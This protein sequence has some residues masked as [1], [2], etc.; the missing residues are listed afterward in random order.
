MKSNKNR[1]WLHFFIFPL[2]FSTLFFGLNHKAGAQNWEMFRGDPQHHAAATVSGEPL[3]RYPA[4]QYQTGGAIFS[5]PVVKD[6]RVYLASSDNFVY[7]LADSTGELIWRTKLGNWIESTPALAN[8]LLYVGCMDHRIYALDLADGRIRW[9]YQTQSWLES[10]PVVIGARL[11][12]GGT[13]HYLYC[14]NAL[15]GAEIWKYQVEK[16][17]YSSPAIWQ[18]FI[19]FGS[20][21]H[22]FYALDSL[23]N[24][25][26]RF[27]TGGYSIASS[28]A[29]VDSLV[30]FGTIDNGVEA[31][32]ATGVITSENNKII[33]LDALTGVVVWEHATENF[34]QMHTSPAVPGDKIYY[35]T[36]QGT[37]WALDVKDGAVNWQA[38]V[39]DSSLVWSSPATASEIIYVATYSGNLFLFS[40]DSGK[41]LAEFAIAVDSVFIH[42]SPAIADDHLFFGASDGK[43]YALNSVVPLAVRFQ[44][45]I[46]PKHAQLAQNYPNPFNPDTQIQYHLLLRKQVQ[47]KIFNSLGQ[48]IRTL[49]NG[50][51]MP[52]T[53]RLQW[54]GRNDQG[55]PVASGNYLYQIRAGKFRQTRQMLL[56]R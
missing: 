16:D 11:Y 13:D 3:L 14:L 47:I 4:W 35:P 36:D 27:Y 8:G 24:L 19:Y 56:L 30:I 20:D 55:H 50:P 28:P 6:K 34:G 17:I 32:R 43:L 46:S 42:S 38:T 41:V 44:K 45:Q 48:E 51:Q 18:E 21:D 29:V 9:Q 7:C 52:G 26:W 33:A 53:Y 22:Y 40:T 2:L 23:G 39:P 5:S 37:L 49:F 10:S 31:G 54:D 12:I 1:S 15:T 25:Q